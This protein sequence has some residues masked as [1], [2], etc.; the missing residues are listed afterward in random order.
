M[1]APAPDDWKLTQLGGYF[2]RDSPSW[3]FPPPS[4]GR[5]VESGGPRRAMFAAACCFAGGSSVAALGVQLQ[6]YL[7]VYLGYGVLGGV[8]W[9]SVISRRFDPQIKWFPTGLVWATGMRSWVFAAARMIAHPCGHAD[10][11]FCRPEFRRCSQTF[12]SMG[13]IYFVAMMFGFLTVR[14]PADGWAPAGFV[15]RGG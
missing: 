1:T 2:R 9:A 3:A 15:C 12:L 6:Q 14:L 8:W 7:D 10:E 13:A 11:A 5:W 4:S